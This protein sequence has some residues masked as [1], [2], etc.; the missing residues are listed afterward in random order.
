MHCASC[1]A[2]VER[3]LSGIVGVQKAHVNL[4]LEEALV[5]YDDRKVKIETLHKAITDIGFSIRETIHLEEDEHI[6][7]MHIAKQRMILSWVITFIVLLFMIPH[8]AFSSSIIGHKTD[9]WIMFMLSLF[10]MAVPARHVYISAYKSASSGNS[11]MDVLIA[12]GTIS[13][14]MVSPL[15]LF[16]HSISPHDFAGIAAMILSFHLTGRYLENRAKGKASEAIRK[17][18]NLGAKTALML[19]DG[20]EKEVPVHKIT[21][22]DV[23]IVKP[24]SKIPTDGIIIS[25]SSTID[26]SIATGE[27]MPVLR[28]EGDSVLGATINLDGYFQAS[29]TKVGSET[30]LAQ[31]IK[32]VSE[33]QHSKV[34]IQLLA[35]R[36][37]AI[38][39][40]AIIA[41]TLVVFSA[42]VFAPESMSII[43]QKITAIIPLNLQIGRAH[44]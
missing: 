27:S 16:I 28:M 25:G 20:V 29:A 24:G 13:S 26:E 14:L 35:D 38:F 44:V 23:F 31:V 9:A 22:G 39:V 32:M 12:L 30:F 40:P 1:S 17:L 18:I 37:T 34:P 15:S 21:N 2:N 11:N 41:I 36:V 42:W 3:T 19:V 43:A 7:R 10:T 4:A 6:K 5:E 33:A 8:M